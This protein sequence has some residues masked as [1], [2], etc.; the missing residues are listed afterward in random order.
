MDYRSNY[1]APRLKQCSLH[2][3][4]KSD[5]SVTEIEYGGCTFYVMKNNEREIAVWSNGP[6]ECYITA[7]VTSEELT[8]II[9][10]IYVRNE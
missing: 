3:M 9:K 6:F 4:Q 5:D 2:G 1:L 7:D 8:D 10:S